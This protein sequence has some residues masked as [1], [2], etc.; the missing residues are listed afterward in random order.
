MHY[1]YFR[2]HEALNDRTPAEVA[3]VKFVYKDWQDVV[4][5][6]E[7]KPSEVIDTDEPHRAVFEARGSPRISHKPKRVRKREKVMTS[8]RGLRW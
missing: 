6:K 5:G 3:G 1:N 8:L 7:D 2:P 4:R